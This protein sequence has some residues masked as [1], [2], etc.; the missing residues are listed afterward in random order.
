MTS[1]MPRRHQS[2]NCGVCGVIAITIS[3]IRAHTH[4]PRTI[5]DHKTPQTPQLI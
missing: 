2:Y 5:G 3:R 1:R 4:A